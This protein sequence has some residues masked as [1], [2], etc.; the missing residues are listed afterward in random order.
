MGIEERS[1]F[2][3]LLD[4]DEPSLPDR[5]KAQN[6]NRRSG[7]LLQKGPGDTDDQGV[8]RES[9]GSYRRGDTDS[10]DPTQREQRLRLSRQMKD[11]D[12]ASFDSAPPR[13]R[14][15]ESGPLASL[16]PLDLLAMAVGQPDE[17]TRLKREEEQLKLIQVIAFVGSSGTGK[18]TRA[19][20]VAHDEHIDYLI[21]DGLLIY[22]SR[23]VA[24]TSAK[25]AATRME[26]V[27]HALFSNEARSATMRRALVEQ[28]PDQLMILGTSDAMITKICG[29]LHLNLPER[30]IR[31]EDVTTEEERHLAQSIR[32]TRGQHT[33]PVPSMEIKHEF[34]GAFAEPLWR[35][36]S[37]LSQSRVPANETPSGALLEDRTVVRPTFST[38][39]SYSISDE[40]LKSMVRLTATEV[41]GLAYV[42]SVG[43][44]KEA[45]GVVVDVELALYYGFEAQ[46]VMQEAQLAVRK[47]IE[48][49]TS[50]N[51][52]LVN[53]S[54]RKVVHDPSRQH[55]PA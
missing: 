22:G 28:A 36:R 24:G 19:V 37:R 2:A 3:R 11:L 4:P 12:Q 33:I 52:L 1:I 32:I 17:E 10:L 30:V 49:L 40:A 29:N 46:R 48:R 5:L 43:I 8:K 14:E 55:T 54:A 20:K 50:I 47:A 26:S 39:G 18:S 21:D 34:S 7:R 51:V 31:I 53:A 16:S 35:L 25:R 15:R 6:K 44:R 23:I 27:R 9:D 45:Y 38:R 13:P 42:T 41:E